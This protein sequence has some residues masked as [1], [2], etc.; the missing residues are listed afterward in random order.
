MEVSLGYCS[1]LEPTVKGSLIGTVWP[2]ACLCVGLTFLSPT[3]VHVFV[4]STIPDEIDLASV[5]L[6]FSAAIC[7]STIEID[8]VLAAKFGDNIPTPIAA[9]AVLSNG[10]SAK[11]KARLVA[12]SIC[13][14]LVWVTIAACC[15]A[16]ARF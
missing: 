12:E 7:V 3:V 11:S 16:L 5:A 10:S 14:W 1:I 4:S 15:S 8:L 13:C 9:T 6:V 2:S